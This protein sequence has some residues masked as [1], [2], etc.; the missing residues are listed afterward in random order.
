MNILWLDIS[1]IIR[2]DSGDIWRIVID[3][4]KLY[5][6]LL[7]LLDENTA[8][9]DGRL[10]IFDNSDNKLKLHDTI[11]PIIDYINL[12]NN[13]KVLQSKLKK[14]IINFMNSDLEV[15]KLIGDINHQFS[16]IKAE[17]SDEITFNLEMTDY[18]TIESIYKF[19]DIKFED[20]ADTLL[21]K[22]INYV[23]IISEFNIVR[24]LVLVNIQAYLT[25]DEL[26]ELI[27]TAKYEEVAI[28]MLE[29]TIRYGISYDKT[30][31]IDDDLCEYY[32]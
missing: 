3:N 27:K 30:L 18:I 29:S 24:I 12:S 21:Q 23:K 8:D 19:L 22:L 4:P 20:S 7:Q 9:N 15:N 17:L 11:M 26:T 14:K 1:E 10:E 28:I 6:K 13:N 32:M 25:I 2:I 31:V 16:L 5:S